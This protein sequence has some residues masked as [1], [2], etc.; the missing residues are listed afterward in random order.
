MATS[1][2]RVRESVLE[3]EPALRST[4]PSRSCDRPRSFGSDASLCLEAC[5][6]GWLDEPSID[7]RRRHGTP[8][9]ERSLSGR[10]LL[11]SS[12][13]LPRARASSKGDPSYSRRRRLPY[14]GRVSSWGEPDRE[15]SRR[16]PAPALR[17]EFLQRE[18]PQLDAH[19]RWLLWPQTAACC[20]FM[21]HRR[22]DEALIFSVVHGRAARAGG[23]STA[24][25]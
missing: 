15:T 11:W 9:P 1:R 5:P 10:E 21:A 24:G 6:N 25:R 22:R 8:I 12:S 19:D 2:S 7:S 23:R 3:A 18:G 13:P 14:A 20:G 4:S 17:V 16:H